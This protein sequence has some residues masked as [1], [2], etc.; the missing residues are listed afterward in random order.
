MSIHQDNKST[1]DMIQEIM[2]EQ[3]NVV[4][5]AESYSMTGVARTDMATL[6]MQAAVYKVTTLLAGHMEELIGE[7]RE[8]MSP[9]E[10]LE[11]EGRTCVYPGC[12]ALPGTK[13]TPECMKE[14]ELQHGGDR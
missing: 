11:E 10:I 4:R 5:T 12:T 2:I 6:R 14:F 3:R 1:G 13:H 8:L 7:V 9:S